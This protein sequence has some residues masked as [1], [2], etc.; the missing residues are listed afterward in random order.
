MECPICGRSLESYGSDERNR[1]V[2]A[3]L[4]QGD[5]ATSGPSES[6]ISRPTAQ[7]S[8]S[9]SAHH[10]RGS[11]SE[12]ERVGT[13]SLSIEAPS[14][15]EPLLSQSSGSSSKLCCPFCGNDGAQ[16]FNH[17]KSC[18]S[19]KGVDPKE[20]LIAWQTHKNQIELEDRRQ[21]RLQISQKSPQVTSSSMSQN[22]IHGPNKINGFSFNQSTSRPAKKPVKSKRITSFFSKDEINLAR[23]I[24]LSEAESKGL[25]IKNGR[26]KKEEIKVLEERSDA[27]RRM[28]LE[29]KI[30]DEISLNQRLLG[31]F[32]AI[33]NKAKDHSKSECSTQDEPDNSPH[34]SSDAC[35][36]GDE[37]SEIFDETCN[38]FK[39]ETTKH[40]YAILIPTSWMKASLDPRFSKNDLI[41]QG[42]DQYVNIDEEIKC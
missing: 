22:S 14:K 33:D 13:F 20:L 25:I 35:Q 21:A 41:A 19:R 2:N 16:T 32:S 29:M 6:A 38:T 15:D 30:S 24:S 10:R 34:L 7:S 40:S 4:D 42:F 12:S 37:N 28:W 11:S 23:A 1:H 31:L 8:A 27:E 36:P 9:S 5:R 39:D 18:A 26:I 17:I 3:C